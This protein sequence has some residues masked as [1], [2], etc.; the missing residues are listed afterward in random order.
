LVL[1]FGLLGY[2]LLQTMSVCFA[3]SANY[4]T[5][6]TNLAYEL[7]DQVRVNRVAGANYVGNYP[8]ATAGCA[9]AVVGANVSAAAFRNAWSCKLRNAIGEGAS[10]TVTRAGNLYTVNIIW[11]DDRQTA[12]VNAPDFSVGAEI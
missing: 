6:A 1:G 3:Q 12:G 4:R 8:A 9:V 11:D 5:Q 7:L 2:A 10:A